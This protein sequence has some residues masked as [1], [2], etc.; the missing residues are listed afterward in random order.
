M[1]NILIPAAGKGSRF[2]EAGFNLPKPLI[3]VDNQHMIVRAVESLKLQGRFIFILQESLRHIENLLKKVAPDCVIIYIDYYT[4]G[5]AISSLLA[6]SHINNDDELI[7]ANCDQIMEWNVDVA[8]DELRQ[9]DAGVVT[10][11]SSDVKHSYVLLDSHGNVKQFAEKKVISN[12]ALTGIHYWK[13]G[14]DFVNSA[15]E[16]INTSEPEYYIAPTYNLLIQQGKKIGIH[17]IDESM[18]HFVGTPQ[19]LKLYESRK[20]IKS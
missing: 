18:I 3:N 2:S 10:L 13:K 4:S 1:M 8:L 6:E 7:I 20:A 16:L 5:A 14:S 19:D 11:K 9:Y 12:I 15:K 17:N